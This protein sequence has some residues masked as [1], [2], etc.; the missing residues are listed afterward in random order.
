MQ[1]QYYFVTMRNSSL[2][3]VVVDTD[4]N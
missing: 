4:I 3:E 1:Y 2:T